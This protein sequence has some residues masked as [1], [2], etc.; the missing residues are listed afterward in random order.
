VKRFVDKPKIITQS[1][2]FILSNILNIPLESIS[3]STS[4]L[5]SILE[6]PNLELE[7]KYTVHG[8]DEEAIHSIYY[9]LDNLSEKLTNLEKLPLNVT[10][11]QGI[12]SLFRGTELKNCNSFVFERLKEK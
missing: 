8:T 9:T 12:D 2:E 3:I 7:N 1:L 11:V 10:S 6:L 5:D 4:H